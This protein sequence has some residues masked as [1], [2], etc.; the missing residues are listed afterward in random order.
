MWE[1]KKYINVSWFMYW[2]GFKLNHGASLDHVI[3]SVLL[4]SCNAKVQLSWS[5]WD[6]IEDK[7]TAIGYRANY[8]STTTTP[9][10]KL[11]NSWMDFMP[12]LIMRN[13][14]L[15]FYLSLKLRTRIAR[16][17]QMSSF[18]IMKSPSKN[19]STIVAAFPRSLANR[20]VKLHLSVTFQTEADWTMTA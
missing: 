9:K 7:K 19:M 15:N 16:R 13:A 10:S 17:R 3:V 11:V 6:V 12:L 4:S 14:N 8:H 1:P 18:A 2:L 20:L 5:L